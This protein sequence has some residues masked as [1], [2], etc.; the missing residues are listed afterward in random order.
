MGPRLLPFLACD[1]FRVDYV[2]IPYTGVSLID[3]RF[4]LTHPPSQAALLDA[5]DKAC[6][7]G[8][9]TGLYR[10][11]HED[12]G[13]QSWAMSSESAILLR[14][15]ARLLGDRLFLPA[16]FDNENSGTRYLDLLESMVRR[17]DKSA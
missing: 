3:F 7:S 16:Y 5:L 14:S 10:L 6:T 9:L 2:L 13:P 15:H 12:S 8:A 17:L 1:K 4:S 11:A